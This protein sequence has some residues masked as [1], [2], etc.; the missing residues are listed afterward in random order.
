MANAIFLGMGILALL[1]FF[2]LRNPLKRI[3]PVGFLLLGWG[4]ICVT[5]GLSLVLYN[6]IKLEILWMVL[7]HAG[8][9]LLGAWLVRG[10]LFPVADT[11]PGQAA[12][13]RSPPEQLLSITR[14]VCLL[15]LVGY[16]GRYL[17]IAKVQGR[18]IMDVQ[19]AYMMNQEATTGITQGGSWFSRIGFLLF[20]WPLPAAVLVWF[21]S[22]LRPADR[23]LFGAASV[24]HAVYSTL[25]AGR[26]GTVF[27]LG[28]LVPLFLI[29]LFLNMT[30]RR[31]IFRRLRLIALIG[32]SAALVIVMLMIM[33]G[34]RTT[35][36]RTGRTFSESFEL[37]PVVRWTLDAAG[38]SNPLTEGAAGALGY[39]T[40]PLQRLSLF[41]DL[42]INFRFY[43]AY[44]FDVFGNVLRRV[45]IGEANYGAA[46]G[47]LFEE[48]TTSADAPVGTFSTCIRDYYLD[49]GWVGVVLGGLVTGFFAQRFY[50][51]VVVDRQLEY[52]PLLGFMFAH[53]TI[54]PLFS[55]LQ[56]AGANY[57]L[58]GAIV[59]FFF[60]KRF[61]RVKQ[62]GLRPTTRNVG[63]LE[64]A[65][66]VSAS[67]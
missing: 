59:A 47:Q 52:L 11:A 4:F 60:L 40:Q 27:T 28:F 15:V 12:L 34:I 18:V 19:E 38:G 5:G 7:A 64:P 43:G 56:A 46:Y 1:L 23:L 32:G 66:P 26:S 57:S 35:D 20:L 6:E 36:R 21:F 33:F 17:H 9:F 41:T 22:V 16:L 29:G 31:Q 25:Q 3:S 54:S 49:F 42:N 63:Q 8:A 50:R 14:L 51:R 45:G 48:Y 2:W 67:R 10:K 44:N 13:L 30:D 62:V 39:V 58:A 65:R 55:G 61:L 24:G 37:S 53:I